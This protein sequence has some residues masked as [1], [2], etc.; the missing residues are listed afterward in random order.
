MFVSVGVSKSLVSNEAQQVNNL[1]T[2]VKDADSW[3]PETTVMKW[4]LSSQKKWVDYSKPFNDHRHQFRLTADLPICC[5]ADWIWVMF[6]HMEILKKPNKCFAFGGT[7]CCPLLYVNELKYSSPF[8]TR[9]INCCML[10]LLN[11]NRAL[12]ITQAIYTVYDYALF[13]V[14]DTIRE[15]HVFCHCVTFMDRFFQIHF[16][17]GDVHFCISVSF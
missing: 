3:Q 8:Y 7:N 13:C 4:S 16:A 11:L 1:L 12:E 9:L 17:P 6:F 15:W 14:F 5:G 2:L 10:N